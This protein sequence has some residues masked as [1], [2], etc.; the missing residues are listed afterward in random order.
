MNGDF[1]YAA[2]DPMALV[3]SGKAYLI[4]IEK[5]HPHLPKVAEIREAVRS[6]SPREQKETLGRARALADFARSVEEAISAK[7]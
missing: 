2:I 3:L 1:F 6:L 5:K 7:A 4:W